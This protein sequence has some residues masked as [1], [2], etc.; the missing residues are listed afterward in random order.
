MVS[1][2]SLYRGI[3]SCLDQV[4]YGISKQRLASEEEESIKSWI[5]EIS[6][7][8]FPPKVA[9]LQKMEKELLKAKSDYKRL[10]KN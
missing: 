10:E 8:R 9:Q 1:K 3:N 2:A 5:L 4:L 6:S 7:W